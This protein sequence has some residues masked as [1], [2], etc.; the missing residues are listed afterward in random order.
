[1]PALPLWANAGIFVRTQKLCLLGVFLFPGDDELERRE[2]ARAEQ[3][4]RTRVLGP[5][6][7]AAEP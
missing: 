4:H 1:M 3:H 2:E 6:V 7:A 5:P